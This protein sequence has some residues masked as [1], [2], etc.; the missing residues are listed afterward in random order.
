MMAEQ[1]KSSTQDGAPEAG[2]HLLAFDSED[3]AVIS[4]NLQDA[5]V[6]IADMAWLPKE[7]RFALVCQRFDWVAAEHGRME[8]CQTGLHF[9]AVRSVAIQG[10]DRKRRD[11]VL[12]L[13]SIT[14][15]AG[16]APAGSIMLT[17]SAGGAVR[18][19]VDYIE[20]QLSDL[21]LRWKARKRPGHELGDDDSG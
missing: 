2:L 17:F 6:R 3:I 12:N 13:L 19:E 15:E 7:R 5:I 4:A 11:R 8:R 1:D 9:D 10:F 21:D 14:F 18:I 20:A 16:D